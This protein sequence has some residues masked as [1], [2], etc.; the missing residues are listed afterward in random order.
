MIGNNEYNNFSRFMKDFNEF[1]NTVSIE[2][3][4]DLKVCYRRLIELNLKSFD[5]FGLG[6]SMLCVLKRCYHLL[7]PD[8]L[9]RLNE[10]FY[11]L[12]NPNVFKRNTNIVS[13]MIEYEQI[14]YETG[15]MNT[16]NMYFKNYK[17]ESGTRVN[18]PLILGMIAPSPNERNMPTKKPDMIT[19]GKNGAK[20][21]TAGVPVGVITILYNFLTQNVGAL[22]TKFNNNG[23]SQNAEADLYNY[24][25]GKY[26]RINLRDQLY[27]PGGLDSFIILLS[28]TALREDYIKLKQ[29]L[30]Q[31]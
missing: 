3:K 16:V 1:L 19:V 22:I 23:R 20:T 15:I 5:I 28:D 25:S 10:F 9:K 14:L 11:S 8:L 2:G 21:A 4:K 12:I 7:K 26:P 30:E 17:L 6:L 13:I 29:D 24:I 31:L 18:D 27:S